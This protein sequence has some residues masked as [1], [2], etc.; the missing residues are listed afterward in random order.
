MMNNQDGGGLGG[1]PDM[2][3]MMLMKM[4]MGGDSEHRPVLKTKVLGLGTKAGT[5]D[6]DS[7][8][9]LGVRLLGATL[10]VPRAE[11]QLMTNGVLIVRPGEFLEGMRF[12]EDL[13]DDSEWTVALEKAEQEAKSFDMTSAILG[14]S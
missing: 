9:T 1:S 7:F 8:G 12:F 5:M 6:Q 2:M 11:L 3:K 4:M 13:A 10:E 14:A